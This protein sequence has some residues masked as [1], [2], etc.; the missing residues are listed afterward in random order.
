MNKPPPDALWVR[1]YYEDTDFSGRVYH[2]SYLRFL[3]R[4]R[5]EWLRRRGFTHRDLAE[6]SGV[7]FAVRS[8]QIEFLAPAM[9]DDLL[10]VET[11]VAAVRGAS[12]KFKQRVDARR[13][14][15]RD[16]RRCWSRQF[17][18]IARRGFPLICVVAFSHPPENQPAKKQSE[19]DPVAA[20]ELEDFAGF[21]RARDR[22]AK[23]LDDLTGGANL[24]GVARREFARARPERILKP[25]ANVAAHRGGH[26]GDR[27]ADCGPLRAPTICIARRTDGQ[28]CASYA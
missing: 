1:V 26:R 17:A 7:A 5:T 9:M 3:E 19:R 11:S 24:L 21:V 13:Q 6:S 27:R 4:G 18:T 28:R 14:G 2:A 20:L 15:A 25:D 16:G 10:E 12:I 8:L 22:E 23:A